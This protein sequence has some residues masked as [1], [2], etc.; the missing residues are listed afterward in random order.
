MS[1]HNH[2]IRHSKLTRQLNRASAGADIILLVR[3]PSGPNTYSTVT[4]IQALGRKCHVYTC[5]LNNR[6]DV[7]S[8]VPQICKRD[9][10][11]IDIL[12]HS[13]GIQH[14]APAIDFPDDKWDDILSVNLTASFLL[15]REF[16]AHWLETSLKSPTASRKKIIFVASVTTYSGSVEIPAYV[17][18]KCGLAGLTRA[19]SNEW[20]GKGINVNAVAPGYIATELTNGIRDGGEKERAVMDR[21]PAGRWGTP[22][23]M[24]AAVIHLASRGS[25]YVGGEI[26][27]VDGGFNAR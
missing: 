22:E 16:A 15:S 23:D 20:M 8:I 4:S 19:L 2:L 5:D 25:D 24:A 27:F 11:E 6:T 10:H 12:V 3:E 14:R 18:S 26:Y 17:A 9:G 21:V 7:L 1:L 13:G